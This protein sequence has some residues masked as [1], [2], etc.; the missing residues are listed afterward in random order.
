MFTQCKTFVSN[1]ETNIHFI[2]IMIPDIT[3][4]GKSI[5]RSSGKG[6]SSNW[7]GVHITRFFIQEMTYLYYVNPFL[8]Q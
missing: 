5:P 7:C 4:A 1:I 8:S 6:F 2:Q 3:I